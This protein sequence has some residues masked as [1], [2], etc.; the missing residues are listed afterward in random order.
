[1]HRLARSV[2][3]TSGDVFEEPVDTGESGATWVGENQ[4]RPATDT[5]PLGLLRVPVDEIYALQPITQ[6][7]WT[8][9][10]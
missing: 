6:S 1:M 10:M 7:F 3:I 2:T 5:P 4:S 9:I 8:T